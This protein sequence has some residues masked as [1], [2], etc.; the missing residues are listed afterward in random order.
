MSPK[1]KP[2]PKPE[3]K[4]KRIDR[5]CGRC[6]SPTGD[7]SPRAGDG[8]C[9]VCWSLECWRDREAREDRLRRLLE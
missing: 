1:D 7:R 2:A 6:D 5:Y 4:R 9:K 8:L 3:P